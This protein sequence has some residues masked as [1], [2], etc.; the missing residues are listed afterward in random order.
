MARN[1]KSVKS[2][3]KESNSDN[4][5]ICKK[6]LVDTALIQCDHCDKWIHFECADLTASQVDK[7]L[8]FFCYDCTTSNRY[9]MWHRTKR[10]AEQE[11]EKDF[12]YVVRNIIGNKDGKN[13]REFLVSWD[14]VGKSKTYPR[15]SWEP[16]H[17]LDS[18]IDILQ[19]YCRTN[20]LPL[21]E[22]EGLVGATRDAVDTRV[23]NWISMPTI[24]KR[25]QKLKAAL[26]IK[27]TLEAAEWSGFGDTD[28]IYFLKHGP[29]CFVLLYIASRDLAFIA[30]G[31]NSYRDDIEI[32]KE[33]KARLSKRLIFLPFDQ[34]RKADH[35]GSSAI[36][37]G[38]QLLNLH[39]K[40]TY[41]KLVCAKTVRDRLTKS[42]HPHESKPILKRLE[43]TQQWISCDFCE[44]KFKQKDGR[45]LNMHII[46]LHSNKN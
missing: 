32:A 14:K 33:I 28:K 44:K 17:N 30:D 7:I 31:T 6:D 10:T 3:A 37:I 35:C 4:C 45:A 24:L 2:G 19:H 21:S 27:T 22:I 39:K 25:F 9:T 23:Q 40:P 20:S 29:H 42:V 15:P 41:K 13:G 11:A 36:L 18:A 1:S 12:Y 5:K 38:I 43:L 34:Q 46:K 16:E 26:N 8:N